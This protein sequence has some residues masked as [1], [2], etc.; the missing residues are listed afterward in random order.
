M[1]TKNVVKSK[2]VLTDRVLLIVFS[3]KTTNG[4]II[5]SSV[6]N[7]LKSLLSSAA[8]SLLQKTFHKVGANAEI[9]GF[10]SSR[11]SCSISFRSP[12]RFSM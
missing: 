3:K 10:V 7:S 11:L 4:T 12:N 8:F 2:H 1:H 6:V 5:D 9:C